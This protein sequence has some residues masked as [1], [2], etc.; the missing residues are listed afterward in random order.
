MIRWISDNPNEPSQ[1]SNSSSFVPAQMW[2]KCGKSCFRKEYS[3]NATAALSV[4]ICLASCI[5][6]QTPPPNQQDC[7]DILVQDYRWGVTHRTKANEDPV[8]KADSTGRRMNT[9]DNPVNTVGNPVNTMGVPMG[10]NPVRPQGE[11]PA[12]DPSLSTLESIESVEVRRESYMLVKNVSAKI[13]KAI[14]W[15]FV[16][17][18]DDA[19]EHELKR[20]RYHT[21]KKIAPGGVGFVSEYVDDRAASKFQTVVINR[22]EFAD[23]TI[24]QR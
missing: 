16:F 24:W 6:A 14:N 15:E 2:Y 8:F 11:P 1:L 4:I 9:R 20:Y 18:S 5:S 19:R 12:R 21:R 13:I 7:P 23:G 22:I 10:T 17:F 3:M